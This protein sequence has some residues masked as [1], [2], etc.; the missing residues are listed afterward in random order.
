MAWGEYILIRQIALQSIGETGRPVCTHVPCQEGPSIHRG[1]LDLDRL[2][3]T[4]WT[5][6]ASKSEIQTWCFVLGGLNVS[7]TEFYSPR[8]PCSYRIQS[9]KYIPLRVAR[10][11]EAAGDEISIPMN[12]CRWQSNLRLMLMTDPGAQQAECVSPNLNPRRLPGQP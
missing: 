5:Q 9:T 1:V 11:R 3:T 10:G 12:L 2:Y 4:G 8:N 7:V 6:I